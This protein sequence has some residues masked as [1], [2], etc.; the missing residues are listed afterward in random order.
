MKYFDFH[1][2]FTIIYSKK[3]NHLLYQKEVRHFLKKKGDKRVH[4]FVHARDESKILLWGE[5]SKGDPLEF[6]REPTNM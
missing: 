4:F 5:A 6:G 3:T 2:I 1:R